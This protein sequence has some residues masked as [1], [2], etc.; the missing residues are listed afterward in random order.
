MPERKLLLTL[1]LVVVSVSSLLAQGS[2]RIVL[3]HFIADPDQRSRVYITDAGG[4]EQDVTLTFYSETGDIVGQKK[5]PL[6][7]NGTVTV[8]PFDIIQR[9]AYGKAIAEA[10]SRILGEYWQIVETEDAGYSVSVPLQPALGHDQLLVQHF[11]SDPNVTAN[12]YVSDTRGKEAIPI[13][14]EFY[15]EMSNLL[16]KI[17]KTVPSNGS[18]TIKPWDVLQKKVVGSA[19]IKTLGGPIVGEYW[20]IVSGK[21]EDPKTQKKRFVNYGVA[22][23][24]AGKIETKLEAFESPSEL[25]LTME[26]H[27]DVDK[28]DIRDVDKPNIEE[29]S[30]VIKRYFSDGEVV[31]VEGHTDESGA[32]DHNLK[33]SQ[34]RAENVKAYLVSTFGIKDTQLKAVGYGETRPAVPGATGTAGQVNRRVVFSI[35]KI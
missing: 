1:L 27:F 30:K 28:A 26:V 34:A 9:R 25:R 3:N 15:D 32:D 16:T 14:L 17:S 6:A 2:R 31:M 24:L 35:P 4:G 22:V 19:H 18:I 12:I 11:V 33:L 21:F 23:S 20:Q 29:A 7:A 8:N 5:F 13:E 10:S